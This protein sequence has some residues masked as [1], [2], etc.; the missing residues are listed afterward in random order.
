MPGAVIRVLI[1]ED[2][3]VVR[4]TLVALLSL[5]EDI[6]VVAS[7]ASGDRIVAAA[8]RH[9]PDVALLDIDLPG[10]DGLSAAAEL[11]ARLPA[12][13]VLIL[14]GLGTPENLHRAVETGVP[15]FLLKDGPADQ[16]IQ[17]VRAVARGDRVIDRQL[18]HLTREPGPDPPAR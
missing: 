8:V 6:D 9:C 18:A 11:A 2:V 4:E 5:E 12:C 3:R 17:A 1:A 16:L 14:T 7:L 13:R 10:L 15:G